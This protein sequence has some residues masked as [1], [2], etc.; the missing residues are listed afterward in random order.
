MLLCLTLSNTRPYPREPETYQCLMSYYKSAST[1]KTYCPF[2]STSYSVET[3]T[4]ISSESMVDIVSCY[5]K[6]ICLPY[7]SGGS[8]IGK[9]RKSSRKRGNQA[10]YGVWWV[11]TQVHMPG[12]KGSSRPDY[13]LAKV[14]ILYRN[15]DEYR[16]VIWTSEARDS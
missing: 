9:S 1:P 14:D 15:K 2:L 6:P 7:K 3:G 12:K 8:R 4:A 10:R 5:Q 16:S 13:I 11:C